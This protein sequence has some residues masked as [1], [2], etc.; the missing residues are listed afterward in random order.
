MGK[1]VS[2]DCRTTN[3]PNNPYCSVSINIPASTQVY[4]RLRSLYLQTSV[5]VSA[6]SAGSAVS[7]VGDQAVIDAT[8]KAQDI[9]RRIQVR[10]P[11]H[12]DAQIPE[13]AIQTG[14]TLCK[15]LQIAAASPFTATTTDPGIPA[16]VFDATSP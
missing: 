2:G 7:L 12:H 8:G 5:T 10:I 15:R 1:I 16:C 4:L 6:T 11:L 14:D 13:F 3:Y 9:L